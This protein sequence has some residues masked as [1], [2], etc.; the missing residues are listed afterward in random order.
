MIPNVKQLLMY[1]KYSKPNNRL[2]IVFI[3][4]LLKYSSYGGFCP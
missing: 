1:N 4:K 3:N 2:M